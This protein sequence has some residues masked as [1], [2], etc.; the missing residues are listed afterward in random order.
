MLTASLIMT[1]SLVSLVVCVCHEIADLILS[2]QPSTSTSTSASKLA[3]DIEKTASA[4]NATVSAVCLDKTL[5]DCS[6]VSTTSSPYLQVAPIFAPFESVAS[7]EMDSL[8]CVT[9]CVDTEAT[10]TVPTV[11]VS[12]PVV[13]S[14]AHIESLPEPAI[15]PQQA[16]QLTIAPEHLD[17]DD[18]I[19][20][21]LP[22]VTLQ[23]PCTTLDANF[24]EE[25]LPI[26]TRHFESLRSQMIEGWMDLCISAPQPRVVANAAAKLVKE[27]KS[28][29][30]VSWSS[31]SPSTPVI[32]LTSLVIDD[33]VER[34]EVYV[35]I[36]R[37]AATRPLIKNTSIADA[38]PQRSVLGRPAFRSASP[39]KQQPQAKVCERPEPRQQSKASQRMPLPTPSLP[40]PRL[41][42]TAVSI[43]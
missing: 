33:Y 28:E 40:R 22:V 35:E 29:G 18:I 4:S 6:T 19:A 39:A 30:A 5:D 13:E 21:A 23:A 10:L 43:F 36:A 27:E 8:A 7:L 3:E 11:N 15:V 32:S 9:P 34:R 37:I 31:T 25:P 12:E 42:I 41:S 38:L 17:M 26:V 14:L 2:T 16:I 1:I 20:T 24:F